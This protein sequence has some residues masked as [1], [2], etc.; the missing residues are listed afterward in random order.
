METTKRRRI[1]I[2]Q[3]GLRYG[4][5]LAGANIGFFL[6]MALFS[7]EDQIWLRFVNL[8]FIFLVVYKGLQYFKHHTQSDWTYLKGMGL[9]VYI[10]LSGSIL[11]SLFIASYGLLNRDFITTINKTTR[12]NFYVSPITMALISF[13]E[14]VLSGF[15]LVFASM[16]RL[17]TSHMKDAVHI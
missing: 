3:I 7:L 15:I 11:F 12:V 4:L 10:L 2:E 9:G 8:T 14:T 13:F 17:K 1:T 5:I 16:Q 6:L